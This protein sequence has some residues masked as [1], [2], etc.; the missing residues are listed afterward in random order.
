[1]DIF[2]VISVSSRP[3]LTQFALFT[4]WTIL[5]AQSIATHHRSVVL[6]FLKLCH[7]SKTRKR[8]LLVSLFSKKG[9]CNI[10]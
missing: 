7:L 2:M 8:L 4:T 1:M 10:P 6:I 9:S 3:L 5:A